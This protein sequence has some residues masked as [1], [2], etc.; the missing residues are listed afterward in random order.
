MSLTPGTRLGPYEI[1]SA[2]GAGGMGEVYRARD[3][4]LERDVAIKI[5]PATSVADPVARTRLLR[6]ARTASQLNHP[7][8]CTIYQVGEAEGHAFIAMVPPGEQH[9]H[10]ARREPAA[11]FADTK[12]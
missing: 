4:Q 10:V 8:I 2:L 12:V 7:N 3:P 1:V 5:L 11:L 6:E 9:G